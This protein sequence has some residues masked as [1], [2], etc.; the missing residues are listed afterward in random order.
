MAALRFEQILRSHPMPT[1]ALA[2]AVTGWLGLLLAIPPGYATG[3]FPPAGIA[4]VALLAGGDRLWPGVWLGSFLLNGLLAN[5]P[6]SIG[7]SLIAAGIATGAALQARLGAYLVRRGVGYPATLTSAS[8]ALRF[9]LLGG[10]LGCLVSPTVGVATL[11]LAGKLPVANAPINWGTW[12]VGDAL[13]VFVVGPLLWC[14]IGEPREIWRRRFATLATTL[15]T[16]LALVILAF[17]WA[18]QREM[19]QIQA[20]FASL[21]RKAEGALVAQINSH[22]AALRGLERFIAV[23][24]PR[25]LDPGRF[26]AFAG[27]LVNTQPGFQALSWNEWVDDS[28]RTAFEARQRRDMPDFRI[29]ERSPSGGVEA[30]A[31]RPDYVVV[32]FVA[33]LKGNQRALGFDIASDPIRAEAIHRAIQSRSL[34][35]TSRIRLVQADGNA[36]FGSLLLLPYFTATPETTEPSM[37]SA[38]P[39][40]FAVAVLRW[41]Y[42]LHATLAAIGSDKA[43]ACL[44]DRSAPKPVRLSGPEG[45]DD[46]APAT[47]GYSGPFDLAGRAL[48]LELRPRGGFHG[49]SHRA[50][51]AWILLV[52]GVGFAGMLGTLIL[53]MSGEKVEIEALVDERT[54]ALRSAVGQLDQTRDRLE[55]ALKG[56]NQA[57]WHWDR[58]YGRIQVIDFNRSIFNQG[59]GPIDMGL[60]ELVSRHLDPARRH[61]E[62]H[63]LLGVLRG[64]DNELAVDLRFGGE[65]EPIRW[66]RC[67]GRVLERD[68][69]GRAIR[70]AGT[71]ADITPQR[72]AELRLRER[73]A[74]L[75][76]ITD[77]APALI[78]HMDGSRRLLF[79]NH[80]LVRFFSCGSAAS[81]GEPFP[82]LLPP[83]QAEV[84][85]SMFQEARQG[86]AAS[87]ELRVPGP[88][89]DI[90]TLEIKLV[91]DGPGQGGRSAGCI[92]LATDITERKHLEAELLAARTRAEVASRAKSA[93]LAN[94][95][96]EVRTPLNAALGMTELVLTTELTTEQRDYLTSALACGRNLLAILNEVLDFAKIDTEAVE[97]DNVPFEPREWVEATLAAYSTAAIQK[98]LALE[99][100]IAGNLPDQLSGDPIRIRKVLNHLIDNAIKFTATGGI[101]VSVELDHGA[102]GE[103]YLAVTVTDSG[104]G[105]APEL[106]DGIFDAFAQADTSTT[107]SHGGTGLGL[108]MA[109][110]L[111]KAMGGEISL[112]SAQ[113]QGSTFSFHVRVR[114]P[115]VQPATPDRRGFGPGLRVLVAEDDR[116][117]R[118]VIARMIERMGHQ[119]VPV[120]D[121]YA[122]LEAL[123]QGAFDLILMDVQMPRVDGLEC[124]RMIRNREAGSGSGH[125]MIVALTADALAKDRQRCLEAGM[126]DFLPK[127]V[128]MAAL[129][130]VVARV[131]RTM[132]GSLS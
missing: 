77:N 87:F 125:V 40:G 24:D 5:W 120:E 29:T 85:D 12:W 86:P 54:L 83:G 102:S 61:L 117:N 49:D 43:D 101:T 37:A 48:S 50:L 52:A 67:L 71:L 81:T 46:L 132:E 97:V 74:E 23:V 95:S 114:R 42:L 21:G 88:D 34:A 25:Q 6:P 116:T 10:A 8:Q 1:L 111:V 118:F 22:L 7:S 92:L 19:A 26:L 104:I 60:R 28:Q 39:V 56:S 68:S 17:V 128:A 57:L 110:R 51:D 93:F 124:T 119:A 14:L 76:S 16:S 44:V 103:E 63:S 62:R 38:P 11:S 129:E 127:P 72:E 70:M 15:G 82:A 30:A 126:D 3:I 105:I 65:S 64:T 41:D 31:K 123:D 130:G 121:G 69:R 112:S 55:M 100:S 106:Q 58:Q 36:E 66:L 79:A 32:T 53:S 131:H 73:E 9:A 27:P 18:A 109:H 94:M 107:R 35:A 96:H 113:G 84:F 33:P 90:R 91:A 4:L 75:R 2:Y 89:G 13:G 80:Q 99:C 78:A 47:I 115:N 45:C 59:N 20:E 108:A 98:G 122:A